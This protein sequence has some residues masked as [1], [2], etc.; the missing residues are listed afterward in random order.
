ML[1]E[2]VQVGEG[3]CKWTVGRIS[4]QD[5]IHWHLI[6]VAHFVMVHISKIEGSVDYLI[7]ERMISGEY[8]CISK[9]S[10]ILKVNVSE[11]EIIGFCQSTE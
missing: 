1:P 2:M 8:H 6:S 10:I 3:L 7:C 4:L 5:R 9:A 11:F